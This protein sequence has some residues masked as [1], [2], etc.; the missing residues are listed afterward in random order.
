MGNRTFIPGSEWVYFKLYT[1]TKTADS[2]LKNELY[3]YVSKMLKNGI[4]DKW[5]FIRYADPDFHVRL[6]LHLK[7]SRDFTCVFNQF[8]KMAIPLIGTG[9]GVK[10]VNKYVYIFVPN[11]YLCSE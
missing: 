10:N 3:G 8:S 2:I 5:F 7:E 9:W 6:R 1:G 4:I 11:M